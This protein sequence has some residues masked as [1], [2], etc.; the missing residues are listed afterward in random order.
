M[1]NFKIVSLVSLIAI[2]LVA[3][4]SF[5]AVGKTSTANL[6]V[7]ATL[8]IAFA[9]VASPL[10]K[11]L[12]LQA[13]VDELS[14]FPLT[15]SQ[16]ALWDYLMSEGDENTKVMLRRKELQIATYAEA[17]KFQIPVSQGGKIELLNATATYRQGR[18]AL[19]YNQG[20]LPKGFNIAV[21]K[22]RVAYGTD[23]ALLPEAIANYTTVPAGWPAALQHGQL[24]IS[25]NNA[26][27]EQFTVRAAGSAAASFGAGIDA[28]GL[29]LKTPM[30]L[31]EGKPLKIELFCPQG[32]TFPATPAILAVEVAFLGACV[33]PRS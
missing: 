9:P 25:Q 6:F 29:E 8:A 24:I 2:A 27:K 13:Y 5:A 26:V 33:R 12:G 18:L 30:I 17:L 19:E 15:M 23:A 14:P 22:I 7:V 31:E 21:E 4:V 32:V 3:S 16:R 10:K 11:S 20:F 28:D 1:K